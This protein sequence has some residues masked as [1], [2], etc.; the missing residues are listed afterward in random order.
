L[1]R[2]EAKPECSR[3]LRLQ[4]RCTWSDELSVITDRP[5]LYSSSRITSGQSLV[6]EF[7]NVDRVTI[8]YIHYSVTFC[9]K[10][11][12]YSNESEGNPFQEALLPLAISSLALLYS[13]A[14][15]A[16]VYLARNQ[17]QH[18]LITQHHYATALRD[19]E[20]HPRRFPYSP[21]P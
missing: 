17:I 5:L 7:P 21:L 6:V 9:C 13:I 2:D 4:R 16:A 15:I 19:H 10:F 1:Q 12:T 8:P 3:C 11:L 18:Q 14:A 20:C